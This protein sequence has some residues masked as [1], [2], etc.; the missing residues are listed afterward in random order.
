M[1]QND[2][3]NENIVGP[4]NSLTMSFNVCFNYGCRKYSQINN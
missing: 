4:F 3:Q 2:R 1:L